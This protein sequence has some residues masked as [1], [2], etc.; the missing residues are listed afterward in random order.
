MEAA[1]TTPYLQDHGRPWLAM[2]VH[3]IA[4][5]MIGRSIDRAIDRSI[6]RFID[7]AIDRVIDRAIDRGSPPRT[8]VRSETVGF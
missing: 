1:P 2:T 7:R 4:L 5:A 8:G 3:V 6:D